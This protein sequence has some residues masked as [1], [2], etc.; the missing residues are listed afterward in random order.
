MFTSKSVQINSD[1]EAHLLVMLMS[2]FDQLL[3][4]FNKTSFY[5]NELL[6]INKDINVS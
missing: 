1:N 6:S 3:T 4:T 2:E 5:F